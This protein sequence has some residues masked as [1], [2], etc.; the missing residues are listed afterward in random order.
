MIRM[1]YI[2]SAAKPMSDEALLE[3]LEECRD[4][5]AKTGITGMLLYC[6]ESFIHEQNIVALL[7]QHFRKKCQAQ[8][9]H[10]DLPTDSTISRRNTSTPAA[11]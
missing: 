9:A 5:N 6:G 2:S 7:M 11:R 8:T 4:N 3:L 1:L 10:V